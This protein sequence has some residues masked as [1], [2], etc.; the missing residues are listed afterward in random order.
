MPRL[1]PE[2]V[3]SEVCKE[4][5]IDKEAVIKKEMKRNKTRDMGYLSLQKSQRRYM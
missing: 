2:A 3:V 5:A 4:F 1:T